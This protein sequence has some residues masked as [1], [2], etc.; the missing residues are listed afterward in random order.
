[1]WSHHRSCER[2]KAGTLWQL[3]SGELFDCAKAAKH[4]AAAGEM[5]SDLIPVSETIQLCSYILHL[6]LVSL[7]ITQGCLLG[8]ISGLLLAQVEWEGMADPSAADAV[9]LVMPP[10]ADL[11]TTVP[12]KY[13]WANK[14]PEHERSGSGH[15][16]CGPAA[17]LHGHCVM[18]MVLLGQL[19]FLL[20]I[21]APCKKL[22]STES[23]SLRHL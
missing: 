13:K 2:N 6:W 12:L 10:D 5:T 17:H 1:M 3:G 20:R 11:R 7:L 16:R 15:L 18:A 8:H 23:C 19:S 9:A 21:P 14:S 22:L 4:S